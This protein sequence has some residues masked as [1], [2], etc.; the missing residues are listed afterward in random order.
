MLRWIKNTRLTESGDWNRFSTDFFLKTAE[1]FHQYRMFSL[2]FHFKFL[3]FDF[4]RP[5]PLP[6]HHSSVVCLW[7]TGFYRE[8]DL[9]EEC[10]CVFKHL[11]CLKRIGQSVTQWLLM[12]QKLNASDRWWA[13]ESYKPCSRPVLSQ[14]KLLSES[15]LLSNNYN[16]DVIFMV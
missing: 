2:F 13:R 4:C 12:N 15:S 14:L 9:T 3:C 1:Y 8:L 16:A 11:R 7:W 10:L 6:F 5:V